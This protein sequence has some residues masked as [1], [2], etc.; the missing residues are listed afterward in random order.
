MV[1]IPEETV[2]KA[3][4]YLRDSV[5]AKSRA[6]YEFSEKQLKVVLAQAMRKSN[7]KS[8]SERETEALCSHE[9]QMALEA[10]Q[11]V[12]ELYFT[13]KDKREA[14]S[15]IIEGWRTQR[16]DERAAGRVAA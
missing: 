12:S 5:H 2:Q 1:H 16:S 3:F 14:A 4:D 10:H 8:V 15:A 11:S 9:Y 6:A 7:G 13:A